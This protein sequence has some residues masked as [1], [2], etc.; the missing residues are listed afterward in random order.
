MIGSETNISPSQLQNLN[1]KRKIILSLDFRHGSFLGDQKL[2][3]HTA[4]WPDRVILMSLDKVGSDTGPDIERFTSIH[5]KFSTGSIYLAGGVRNAED[6]A[7]LSDTSV[8]GVLIASALHNKSLGRD[9]IENY[10][11]GSSD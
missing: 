8:A 4:N 3:R 11:S 7:L 1:S 10:M 2:L 9:T 5:K 6:L